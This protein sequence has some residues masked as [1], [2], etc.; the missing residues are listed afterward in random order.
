ML[1]YT[2]IYI[3]THMIRQI[4]F[5]KILSAHVIRIQLAFTYLSHRSALHEKIFNSIQMY[6]ITFNIP[7]N[8][9][10]STSL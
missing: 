5:T 1:I 10:T 6:A 4:F 8:T 2:Y 7:L 9:G 3:K